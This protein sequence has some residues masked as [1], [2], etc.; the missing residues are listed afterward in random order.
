MLKSVI[1]RLVKQMKEFHLFIYKDRLH[2]TKS[3][4]WLGYHDSYSCLLF[5]DEINDG[6]DWR[7]DLIAGII[8]G[9]SLLF[10][11]NTILTFLL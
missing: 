6:Q 7:W 3:A 11:I 9:T 8:A 1:I 2:K 4:G 10:V 5:G